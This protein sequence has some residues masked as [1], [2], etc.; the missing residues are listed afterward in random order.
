MRMTAAPVPSTQFERPRNALIHGVAVAAAAGIFVVDVQQPLVYD[1]G[2]LYVLVILLGLWTS[3][4]AYAIVTA[5]AATTLLIADAVIGW[6]LAPPAFIF[7]NRPLM[8]LVLVATAAL[9]MHFKR[10]ERRRAAN[11]Q[12][13]ADVKRALDHRRSL[14]LFTGD[15]RHD[16]VQTIVALSAPQPRSPRLGEIF[17]EPEPSTAPVSCGAPGI[18]VHDVRQ[19]RWTQRSGERIGKARG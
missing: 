10:L 4:Q 11:M 14:Q 5:V 7:V 8:V 13:L 3:W 19:A 12:Q 1:V 9:V 17:L 15:V 6:A 2:V 18:R 16:A